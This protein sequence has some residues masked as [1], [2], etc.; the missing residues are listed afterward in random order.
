MRD[1]L[2][3]GVKVNEKGAGFS[4]SGRIKM[5]K[6]SGRMLALG[7]YS[8]EVHAGR[9]YDKASYHINGTH[10]NWERCKGLDPLLN[11]DDASLDAGLSPAAVATLAEAFATIDAL[12]LA[13]PIPNVLASAKIKKSKYVGVL[14]RSVRH[15]L[16][17]SDR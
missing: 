15:G 6:L 12:K 9:A 5:K 17:R 14:C 3:Q 8:C 4:C 1:K 7:T 16:V 10:P 11:P 13:V 2:I